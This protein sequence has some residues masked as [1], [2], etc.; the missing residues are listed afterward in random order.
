MPSLIPGYEYDV[1]I[2]YRQNDNRSGW[3]TQFVEH[4]REELAA[5]IKDTVNIYFDENPH[6]GLLDTHH[7]DKSLEG[8]LK[9]VIFIPV[10]S[11]TY[12]DSKSFAWN[13]E[14]LGFCQL[15]KADTLGLDVRLIN[16]NVAS[17]VL[18]VQIHDLDPE[19]QKLFEGETGGQLRSIDFIFR[20]QGVNRPLTPDDS[21]SENSSKTLYRDQINKTANAVEHTLKSIVAPPGQSAAFN[22]P[23]PPTASTDGPT[24]VEHFWKELQRRN[25]LRA[26]VTYF[27]VG[28]LLL[29]GLA[30]VTPFLQ[31]EEST[32]RI[33]GMLL[34]AGFP[35]AVWM[36]WRYEIS[37]QGFIRT[38]SPDSAN[39][40]YTAHQKKP[41]TSGTMI[42]VL[43]TAL[44]LLFV[45]I[46]IYLTPPS[47]S[48][49]SI[50]IAV[51]P[52]ENRSGNGADKYI[53]D[54]ISDDVINRL[55]FSRKLVV[56]SRSSTQHFS[57]A[58][59]LDVVSSTLQVS[60]IVKGS[61]Q[62][63]GEQILVTAQ[64]LDAMGNY[65][66]G[67]TFKHTSENIILVQSEI[68]RKIVQQLKV[69]LNE[70]E[71]HKLN[72]QPTE[73]ATA[74]DC[75][76]RGRSLY[77]RYKASANDS[78]ITQFRCAIDLDPNYA[79]AWAGLGDALS[80][81]HGRFGQEY[82]WTD[83]GLV[84]SQRAIELDSGLS[85]GYKAMA[86]AYNYRKEYAKAVPYLEKA[87][88]ISPTYVQAVGNLGITYL[89]LRDLPNA[90]KWELTCAGL[91]PSNWVPY[92]ITGWTFRLLGDLQEAESW[93]TQ[94]LEKPSGK[95]FDTYEQLGYTYVAQG[96][97][98]KALEL[99]DDLIKDAEHDSRGLETAGL[100]ANFAGDNK[101][102]ELYFVNSI[103]KNAGYKD[104]LNTFSPIGLGQIRLEQG[105]KI[106]AEVYL[107]H[108]MFNLNSSIEKGSQSADL[109]YY[110]AAIYAIRGNRAQSLEWLQKAIDKKWLDYAM[111][112]HGPYFARY[113]TD[114]AFLNLVKQLKAKTDRM[115]K[116]A[117]TR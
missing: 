63:S 20:S 77:Y 50:S 9:C 89:N 68:A 28:L 82:F 44:A 102:A 115:L 46:K 91:D 99:I 96:R 62:R 75:Y 34:A 105:N 36:A 76:L 79:R 42:V 103:E 35:L 23:T 47:P 27:I 94:S 13:N 3:V 107:S 52:F 58:T 98:K 73:S 106:E 85:E 1:F 24:G 43:V 19:D 112:E 39:N 101:T 71:M 12:C 59:V 29:Q 54:G 87:V 57:E 100:I 114:P 86:V 21:R 40:P 41:L 22:V 2:S 55:T 26:A 10:L 88:E 14:F 109:P 45:Y 65:L 8:K 17:R 7:V 11:H 66:W 80:Q 48:D 74:Y 93:L 70:L 51:L 81:K 113:R 72:E 69:K 38:T 15:A 111:I 64:L 30:F 95:R 33:A 37:P 61:V 90:I 104:D 116:E 67:D 18:P 84:A 16:R 108:A 60:Y 56:R 97:K 31:L 25:V 78:A 83:S 92:Q 5:T 4:L 117:A 110:I 32:I 6:D 49:K 53:A